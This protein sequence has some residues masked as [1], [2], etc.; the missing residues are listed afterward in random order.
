MVLELHLV[1]INSALIENGFGEGKLNGCVGAR[2]REEAEGGGHGR[3]HLEGW[4]KITWEKLS[5][6]AELSDWPNSH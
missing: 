2:D 3:G 1:F 5:D 6:V 4:I